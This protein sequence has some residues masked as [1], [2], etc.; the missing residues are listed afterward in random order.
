MSNQPILVV[1]D[2]PKVVQLVAAYLRR[3]GFDVISAGN[4]EAAERMIREQDPRLV[5]LDVM[6]PRVDGLALLQSLR[7]RHHPVPVLMVSAL[8]ALDDR[9]RGLAGGADDYLAKPFSPAELV[10]RVHA[11]LRRTGE[12][13]PSAMSH[14]DL[15]I[16][17]ERREVRRAGSRVDLSPAEFN[18]LAALVR[19]GGR[20]LTRD[21]L[22]DELHGMAGTDAPE[23]SIDVHISRLRARLGREREYLATVR[24]TGYRALLDSPE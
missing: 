22:L 16:D 6:L 7:E 9:L 18:L 15:S 5:V 14:H 21:Q 13:G 23:R 11:I 12:G 24:G 17:L 3:A 1:D 4:G 10:E 19:A 8:G 2:D 20:V